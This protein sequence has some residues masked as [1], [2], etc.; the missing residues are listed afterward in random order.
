MTFHNFLLSLGVG[1][2][3]LAFWF[4]I[5]FPEKT[6]TDFRRAL[7]HVCA[8]LMLGPFTP[9]VVAVLWSYGYATAMA[10]IFAVLLPVLFYTFLSGAW[11]FKLAHDTIHRYRH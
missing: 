10:A 8:A 4:V 3:L 7:L 2:A 5:R 1:S 6:P 9:H 11:F